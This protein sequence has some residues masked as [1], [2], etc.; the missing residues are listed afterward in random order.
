MSFGSEEVN[1]ADESGEKLARELLV[2]GGQVQLERNAL[3]GD[4]LLK[5]STIH[6]HTA[7]TTTIRIRK[8]T[9][10]AYPSACR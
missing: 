3:I 2:P 1:E 6:Q 8:L 10:R 9:W 4:K 5:P 7:T